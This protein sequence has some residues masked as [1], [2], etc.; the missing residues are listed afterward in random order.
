MAKRKFPNDKY[1]NFITMLSTD[2][3]TMEDICQDVATSRADI[4]VMSIKA[5]EQG[6]NIHKKKNKFGA[7]LTMRIDKIGLEAVRESLKDRIHGLLA[8]QVS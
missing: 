6:I 8:G 5:A 3:E 2:P 4:G 1:Y 7:I